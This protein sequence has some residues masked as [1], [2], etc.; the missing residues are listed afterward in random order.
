MSTPPRD[1]RD[2]DHRTGRRHAVVSSTTT[3]ADIFAVLRVFDPDGDE[4]VLQGA[5][6][7]HT[8]IGQ[9]WLRASHR[10]LDADLSTMAALAPSHEVLSR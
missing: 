7:P 8:P 1:D 5:V 2:R 10:K 9:G 4:V 6:D 3:D